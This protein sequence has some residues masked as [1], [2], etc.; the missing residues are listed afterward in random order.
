MKA[1]CG[2]VW[3]GEEPP[4]SYSTS[5]PLMLL[6]GTFG[7]RLLVDELHVGPVIIGHCRGHGSGDERCRASECLD[8]LSSPCLTP[9]ETIRT[10]Y[11]VDRRSQSSKRVAPMRAPSLGT[12]VRS[13]ISTSK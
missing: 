3:A 5:T 7:K 2:C 8:H 4:G 11:C 9:G 12:S 10:V 1:E 6:P 13:S